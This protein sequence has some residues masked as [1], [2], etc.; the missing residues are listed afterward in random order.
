MVRCFRPLLLVSAAVLVASCGI[1]TPDYPEFGTASYRIEGTASSSEGAPPVQT[2]IYRNGA[3]VR[4]E[5]QLPT[6][7]A[8]IVYDD[9]TSAAYIVTPASAA[10]AAVATP[11]SG[12]T[13]TTNP[14][15]T[16]APATT[17]TT[18]TPATAPA[19]ATTAVAP[20]TGTAVRVAD[21]DVP[22]PIEEAWA[23]LGADN[24]KYAGKCT[25]AGEA[26]H[27]WTPK[28]RSGGV[29]RVACI[30]EDG[31]VL[32]IVEGQTALWQASRVERGEQDAALFGVP[33]G[34]Q[35]IDPQAVAQS[36]GETMQDLN[37]V[38]GDPKTATTPAPAATTP[39]PAPK[40]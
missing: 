22:K 1:G 11:A 3:K 27:K 5:T 23:S 37:S 12:A 13:V 32:E 25:V 17:T 24:A 31:I 21:A 38:A 40:K 39:V 29:S 16:T 20:A 33:P 26:G 35:V 28:E 8:S 7:R 19:A 2:T 30:T 9:L 10:P 6:G 18:T 15:T 36:V 34:Y 14:P 4:I